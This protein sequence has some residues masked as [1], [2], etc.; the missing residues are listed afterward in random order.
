MDVVSELKDMVAKVSAVASVED[1]ALTA[2]TGLV[3]TVSDLNT[4]LAAALAA[5]Q[6]PDPAVQQ[7]ADDL[8][9]A[10]Q[11]M[12][13]HTAALSTAIPQNTAPAPDASTTEFSA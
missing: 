2:I 13:D 12:Q 9:T 8:A 3:S 6:N 11:A 4:K 5:S 7:A 10:V 1:A